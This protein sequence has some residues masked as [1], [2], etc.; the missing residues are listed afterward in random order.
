MCLSD[1]VLRYSVPLCLLAPDTLFF[2]SIHK[3]SAV[4]SAWNSLHPD[5]CMSAPFVSPGSQLECCLLRMACSLLSSQHPEG[6]SARGKHSMDVYRRMNEW[7]A[8]T[9]RDNFLP[10]DNHHT[11][12]EGSK[13]HSF[14]GGFPCTL[15]RDKSIP[16][17]HPANDAREKQKAW[18]LRETMSQRHSSSSRWGAMP[19][20]FNCFSS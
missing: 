2:S 10:A 6:C 11:L 17:K 19:N 14:Y 13:D 5:C 18:L 3:G 8:K 16:S 15:G 4:L 20:A 12:S 1:L 9:P 7:A